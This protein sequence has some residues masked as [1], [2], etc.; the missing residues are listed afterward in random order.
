MFDAKIVNTNLSHQIMLPV[1]QYP[2]NEYEK[3]EM[4][5][6]PHASGVGSFMYGLIYSRPNLVYVDIV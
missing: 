6:I 4:K 2:H 1:M 3:K 5:S